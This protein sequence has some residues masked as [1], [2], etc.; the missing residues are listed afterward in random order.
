[1][2]ILSWYS[3]IVIAIAAIA[4][5]FAAFEY[6]TGIKLIPFIDSLDGKLEIMGSIGLSMGGALAI[7]VL[8]QFLLKKPFGALGRAAWCA[9]GSHLAFCATVMPQYLLAMIIGK[10]A[11]G[12][13]A[14][15]LAFLFFSK[16]LTPDP[17]VVNPA[18][19]AAK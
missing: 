11:G 10:L 19:E 2:F 7:V 12:I 9:F 14:V 15:V 1:M 6:L 4:V 17:V 16:S 18:A 3:K 13:I 8:L 5:G